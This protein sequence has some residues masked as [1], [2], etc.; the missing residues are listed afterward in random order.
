MGYDGAH[1][2]ILILIRWFRK[3][4]ANQFIMNLKT[5]TMGISLQCVTFYVHHSIINIQI[6]N[7]KYHPTKTYY[8]AI[9]S[10]STD[11]ESEKAT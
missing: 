8:D 4:I 11:L 6:T 10:N 9:E 1:T 5:T 2:A 3:L 7:Y